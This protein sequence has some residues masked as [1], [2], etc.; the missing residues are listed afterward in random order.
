[1]GGVSKAYLVVYNVC[2]LCLWGLALVEGVTTVADWASLSEVWGRSSK[3]VIVGQL[4]MI[5]EVFH[6]V[7]GMVR[8]PVFTT[9]LQVQ[10][11]LWILF[12]TMAC[13]SAQS[14]P[15]C[16][17][18]VLSWSLVEIVRYSF[19]LCALFLVAAKVPY[20]LFWARY[21]AFFVLYPT[22]IAG[23]L[24]TALSVVASSKD[25]SSSVLFVIKCIMALYIPGGPFM[26]LNMVG[27]RRS[28]F[29]KRFAPPPKPPRG[30]TFPVT[31]S[32]KGSKESTTRSTTVTNK[33][34]IAAALEVLGDDGL[35]A[36]A[37]C[38]KDSN[39]RF[40]YVEHFR[41][42]VRLAAK[43]D[44][45]C[46][47]SSEAGIKWLR[48]NFEYVD[49]EGTVLKLKDLDSAKVGRVLKTGKV[50]GGGG[51]N[52]SKTPTKTKG[53]VV[54]YDGGWHPSTPKAPTETLEGEALKKQC[55]DWVAKGVV[56]RDAADAL[57]WTVDYFS[58]SS[59]S[60]NPLSNV[61][62][63][64]IGAGSAMGPCAKLLEHGANVVAL[65]IPGIWGKGGKRPAS[66]MWK[67]LFDMVAEEESALGSTLVYPYSDDTLPRE[68]AAGADLTTETKEL[69]DWLTQT[70][71]PTVP[72]GSK[73][74]VGNY[75]YLDGDLHVK[76]SLCADI[77][78]ERLLDAAS[79]H[80]K[81][82]CAFLCTPTDAHLV[83]RG[84]F[85]A[86]MTNLSNRKYRFLETLLR[87]ATSKLKPNICAPILIDPNEPDPEK[88]HLYMVDGLSV[89]QGPNY[90]LAKRLQHWRACLAYAK[91]FTASSTVAPS[92]ATIS[93][94]HNKTFAWAYGGMPEF[95][96]EI[97]KQDTTNAVM[98]ALLLHDI[99]NPDSPKNPTAASIMKDK[100][101]PFLVSSLELF[102]SQAVHGGLWRSP[103]TVDSIGEV[104]ALIY[105]LGIAKPFLAPAF[106]ALAAALVAALVYTMP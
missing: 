88:A 12:A 90:A 61:Y 42:L 83:P 98:A 5:L 35:V 15:F 20:A 89:A 9:W 57:K 54:P 34:A 87:Q 86:A 63:V 29:K 101:K 105:F 25:F 91:G 55:D 1:M 71:L 104:S 95:N 41:S 102:S 94:I 22:G 65:D 80:Y 16:G 92:T 73:I 51:K 33:R 74:C 45:A 31:T 103:Y 77:L 2:C 30:C 43:S 8:S 72:K 10:S 46:L 75:T 52:S 26:Y 3:Y 81:A 66:T 67:R 53:Y 78:I 49:A 70:W 11:R 21:S 39:Y 82:A 79:T 17:L 48:D 106:I 44:D 56:E 24:G 38:A 97:F 99:L 19:Y 27:N 28:A 13:A 6:A 50:V 4:L 84:A 14:Q 85:Q 69:A 36:A 47:R 76:L 60:S 64:L 68:E 18:M 7:L 59:S 96:F 62:V 37:K 100:K 32:S 93:V 58:A 40:G 23:E